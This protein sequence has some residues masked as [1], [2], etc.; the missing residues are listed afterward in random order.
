MLI[1]INIFQLKIYVLNNIKFLLLYIL[2]Q[3]KIYIMCKYYRNQLSFLFLKILEFLIKLN[4]SSYDFFAILQTT[5]KCLFINL[6]P[7]VAY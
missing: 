7:E 3:L 5:E 4:Y 6:Y 2:L 1:T